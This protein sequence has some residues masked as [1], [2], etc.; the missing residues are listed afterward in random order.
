MPVAKN[1]VP[2]PSGIFRRILRQ[3]AVTD[4]KLTPAFS[5]DAFFDTRV[6]P[7]AA[8]FAR[9]GI[10]T[11]FAAVQL[12]DR[13]RDAILERLKIGPGFSRQSISMK[14]GLYNSHELFIH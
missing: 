5:G 12:F 8:T 1:S 7:S 14:C 4:E 11:K 13:F 6:R 2:E 10:L 9:P 3:V